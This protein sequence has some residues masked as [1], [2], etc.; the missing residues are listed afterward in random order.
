MR[1]WGTR[2]DTLPSSPPL[3]PASREPSNL[4]SPPSKPSELP[5]SHPSPQKFKDERMPHDASVFVGSL[6]ST[7]D[8]QE[9]AR[10]LSEHLSEHTEVKNIKVVRDSKG[11]VCAF[12]QCEDAVSAATL[13]HT[14][15][16]NPSKSFLG[17]NLRYEPARAFRTLLVSYRT[18]TQYIPVN[19]N[20]ESQ[21]HNNYHPH[22][23]SQSVTL[24]LP[25]AMR[26]WKPANSKFHSLLYN[27]EAVNAEN[28]AENL[29]GAGNEYPTLF[30]KP[31]AFDEET[32]HALASFF[33]RLE[34]IALY[35][36]RTDDFSKMENGSPVE[37]WRLY[38][39]PHDSPRGP[40]MDTRC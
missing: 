40:S 30:L 22:Q 19:I 33:G 4:N 27:N 38:P 37:P 25:F 16:S 20:R 21:V 6:P 11:G 24:D 5:S 2:F 3:S 14:L 26:I 13:I 28:F 12:V 8:Q 15:H 1:T 36:G 7:V 34:S 10:L 39:A 9:L 31:V 17:R 18:P 23:T 32:I 35:P 29:P